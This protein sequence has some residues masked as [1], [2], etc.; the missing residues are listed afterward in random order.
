MHFSSFIYKNCDLPKLEHA[1][2]KQFQ[3]KVTCILCK[4][5]KALDLA[6]YKYRVLIVK[7]QLLHTSFIDYKILSSQSVQGTTLSSF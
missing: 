5:C 7:Q 2:T 4:I 1:L 6:S 3:K